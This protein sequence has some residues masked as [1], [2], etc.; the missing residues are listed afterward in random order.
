M[1]MRIRLRKTLIFAIA[2]A[3]AI[4]LSACGSS[5]SGGNTTQGSAKQAL[6]LWEPATEVAAVTPMLAAFQASTGI[7]VNT[8]VFPSDGFENDLLTKWAAGNRPDIMLWHAIGN[9]L[10]AINPVANLQDLSNM[11]FVQKTPASVLDNSVRYDGKVWAALLD[12]PQV[13]LLDY[14]KNVFAKLGL[15]PPTTFSQLL[16]A[17][18][19]IKQKDPGVAPIVMGGGDTWPVQIPA[20]MMFNSALQADYSLINGIN[21]NTVHFTNTPF[22][23]GFQAEQQLQ[24][25]GCFNSDDLSMTYDQS[26]AALMSGKGAMEFTVGPAAIYPD[27]SVAQIDSTE[28]VTSLSYTDNVGSWQEAGTGF[29]LPTTGNSQREAEARQFINFVTG[30][31]YQ[32][33]LNEQKEEPLLEGSQAPSGIPQPYVTAYQIL[34]QNSVPQYQQDLQANYSNLFANWIIAMLGGKMTPLQVAQNM[35]NSF[36]QNAQQVG[37]KGF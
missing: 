24:Q 31:Y 9:W 8:L 16:S 7:K 29:Y 17:C 34:E 32:T 33:Y 36:A 35:Q 30:S 26:V 27:Y 12:V 5:G 13:D 23:R 6:L 3:A 10:V 28:G 21:D 15:Q 14:N 19:T 11:P 20:F 25:Q 2:S 4:A 18:Q 1:N 37:L 22:L